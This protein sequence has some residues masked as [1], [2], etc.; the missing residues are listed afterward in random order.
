MLTLKY[1]LDTLRTEVID[2]F[3]RI[4]RFEKPTFNPV[5]LHVYEIFI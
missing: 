3:F 2:F 5:C 4:S 1:N